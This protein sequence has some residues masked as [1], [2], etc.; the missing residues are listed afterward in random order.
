MNWNISNLEVEPRGAKQEIKITER[1]KI[2]KILTTFSNALVISPPQNLCAAKGVT[3][4]LPEQI[5]EKV[6]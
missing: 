5:T 1:I 3:D 4:R 2:T 6:S